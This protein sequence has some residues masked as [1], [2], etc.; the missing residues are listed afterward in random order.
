M[1]DNTSGSGDDSL[2]LCFSFCFLL[3]LPVLFFYPLLA[4]SRVD[5]AAFVVVAPAAV[6]CV[7]LERKTSPVRTLF[8]CTGWLPESIVERKEKK[9]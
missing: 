8:G 5:V 1:F 2:F 9:T 3:F 4:S 6:E 7:S